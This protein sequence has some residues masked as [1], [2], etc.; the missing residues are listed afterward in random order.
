MVIYLTDRRAQQT[1]R[2]QLIA[3]RVLARVQKNFCINK[4]VTLFLNAVRSVEMF[5][6]F[7]QRV[8]R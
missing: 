3:M 8:M 2:R 6:L 5:V 4:R 1:T 7:Y